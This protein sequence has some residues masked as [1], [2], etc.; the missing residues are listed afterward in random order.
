MSDQLILTCPSCGAKNRVQR[1]KVSGGARPTCGECG[2]ALPVDGSPVTV[3][4]STFDTEVTGHATPVLVDLWAP[5]CGPCRML[6]PTLET[7]AR[8]MAG[9]LRIAKLNVDEN[10]ATADR[11][12]VHGIPTMVLFKDGREVDRMVGAMPK[13]AI[14][15]RLEG[16]A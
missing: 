12:G 14:I 1:A 9:K 2:A 4:D 10:P 15:R 13:Q 5:W 8:E 7:I 11:L 16:I 6:A 3:T